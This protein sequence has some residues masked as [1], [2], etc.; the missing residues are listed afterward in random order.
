[1]LPE[2]KSATASR[3]PRHGTITESPAKMPEQDAWESQGTA[4]SNVSVA[5]SRI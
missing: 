2:M 3:H 4:A 5:T 1:M